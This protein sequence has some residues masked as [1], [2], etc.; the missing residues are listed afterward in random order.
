M[1][2]GPKSRIPRQGVRFPAAETGVRPA[3]P[4]TQIRAGITQGGVTS[5]T[6]PSH[7][8]GLTCEQVWELD[9]QDHGLLQGFL[10]SLQTGHIAPPHVGLLHHDGTCEGVTLLRWPHKDGHGEQ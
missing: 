7:Y 8:H 9:G 4:C 3:H 1:P 10:G 6:A 5:C 2:G